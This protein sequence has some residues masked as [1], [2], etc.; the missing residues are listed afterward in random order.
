MG[1]HPAGARR[2]SA[3]ARSEK[4]VSAYN[5]V[6]GNSPRFLLPFF[7]AAAFP[8][9]AAPKVYTLFPLSQASWG[10]HFH[11]IKPDYECQVAERGPNAPQ[12]QSWFHVP[13]FLY[14]PTG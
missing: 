7:L 2:E 1:H 11:W 6:T 13:N 14:L 3:G 8:P 9:T 10:V 4:I 12:K 5:P